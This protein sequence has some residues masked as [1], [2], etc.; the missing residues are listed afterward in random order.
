MLSELRERISDFV[1]SRRNFSKWYLT[2]FKRRFNP[3]TLIYYVKS[4]VSGKESLVFV[5]PSRNAWLPGDLSN[6]GLRETFEAEA[7][8]ELTSGQ[9][10]KSRY[11]LTSDFQSF[12]KRYLHSFD[13]LE[14]LYVNSLRALRAKE[15]ESS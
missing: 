14:Q 15:L 12:F 2:Q 6:V 13:H 10:F 3:N 9:V 1:E 4:T 7:I 8:A 5:Y 11:T